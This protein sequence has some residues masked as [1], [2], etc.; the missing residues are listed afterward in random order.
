MRSHLQSLNQV[1]AQPKVGPFLLLHRKIMD[2]LLVELAELVGSEWAREWLEHL[3]G[4]VNEQEVLEGRGREQ[5]Q[6][7]AN[8]SHTHAEQMKSR[9]SD[10]TQQELGL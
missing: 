6:F 2:R 4:S 3:N 10:I 5:Q 1:R 7:T 8:P 9:G